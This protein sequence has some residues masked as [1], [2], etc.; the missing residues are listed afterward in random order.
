MSLK[1]KE[2]INKIVKAALK[3]YWRPGGITKEQYMDIN[4][5][6]SRILYDKAA[7]EDNMSETADL[8]DVARKEVEKA[9][10]G[11]TMS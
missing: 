7:E 5:L 11:L 9:V 6:V 8:E 10:N 3:T 2:E 1:A 4:K